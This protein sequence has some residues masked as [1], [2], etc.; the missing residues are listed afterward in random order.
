M[1]PML[2]RQLASGQ[3]CVSAKEE[4]VVCLYG[5]RGGTRCTAGMTLAQAQGFHLDL[6]RAIQARHAQEG[7]D[8]ATATQSR[9][10]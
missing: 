4:I 5:P 10:G 8:H 1:S 7:N 9:A 2:P 6:G 3:A